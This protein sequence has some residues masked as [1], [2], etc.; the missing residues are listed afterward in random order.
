M[1]SRGFTLVELLV[2][3]LLLSIVA[4]GVSSFVTYATRIYVDS[5]GWSASISQYRFGVQRLSRELRDALPGSVVVG[6]SGGGQ[7]VSF[8]PI[9]SS[10]H[11]IEAP[12]HN[13]SSKV[14]VF[15]PESCSDAPCLEGSEFVI[16]DGYKVPT[17]IP[18]VKSGGSSCDAGVCELTL[19]RTL[20]PGDFSVGKRFFVPGGQIR[21]CLTADGNLS[22]SANGRTSLMGEGF[23]NNLAGCVPGN[24]DNQQ[25]PFLLEPP[26]LARNSVVKLQFWLAEAG[27]TQRFAQEVQVENV[28]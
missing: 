14:S 13:D 21:Y 5:Q 10:G 22:R 8:R 6:A 4:I 26:S 19:D 11:F 27:Q 9:L 17:T 2:T 20:R 12:L 15:M 23:Q 3:L 24:R 25:C 28:P 16:L 18:R 1:G 7:C